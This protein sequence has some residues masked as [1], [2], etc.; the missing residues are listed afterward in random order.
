LPKIVEDFSESNIGSSEVDESDGAKPGAGGLT[1]RQ[2]RKIKK[3][4]R[5]HIKTYN[6]FPIG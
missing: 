3:A 2:R 6:V 1:A 4:E 5:D